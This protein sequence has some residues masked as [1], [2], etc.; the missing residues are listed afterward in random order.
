VIHPLCLRGAAVCVYVIYLSIDIVYVSSF[1]Y[2]LTV[3][4]LFCILEEK[5]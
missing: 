2:L 4:F 3:K 5:T 1:L